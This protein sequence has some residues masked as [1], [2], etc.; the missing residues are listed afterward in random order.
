MVLLQIVDSAGQNIL[1]NEERKEDDYDHLNPK[2]DYSHLCT[3]TYGPMEEYE[4][5]TQTQGED[6]HKTTIEL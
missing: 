3:C 1:I 4:E 6:D 5:R 2:G